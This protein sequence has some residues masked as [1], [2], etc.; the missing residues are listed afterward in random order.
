[1]TKADS[2]SGHQHR[3]NRTTSRSHAVDHPPT[4]CRATILSQVLRAT[5]DGHGRR[6]DLRRLS[7]AA[8]AGDAYWTTCC[9]E[10]TR[11]SAIRRSCSVAMTGSRTN[12][13]LDLDPRPSA[14]KVLQPAME[15][16]A[17]VTDKRRWRNGIVRARLAAPSSR[18]GLFG[19][20][21]GGSAGRAGRPRMGEASPRGAGGHG[22]MGRHQRPGAQPRCSDVNSS[23]STS[24]FRART[25]IRRCAARWC[26]GRVV[27]GRRR[28]AAYFPSAARRAALRELDRPSGKRVTHCWG[29]ASFSSKFWGLPVVLSG[30]LTITNSMFVPD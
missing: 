8:R 17:T 6:E 11:K 13:L 9:V 16:L 2:G 1:M 5:C 21:R 29:V 10:R 27:S 12:S 25:G 3:S 28:P 14:R 30:D 19:R 4:S 15:H 26:C 7:A 23:F 24:M 18:Q 20:A 22:P